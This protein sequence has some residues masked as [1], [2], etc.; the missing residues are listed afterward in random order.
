MS[1]TTVRGSVK[2]LLPT[3]GTLLIANRG[4]VILENKFYTPKF[5]VLQGVSSALGHP[6]IDQLT[7]LDPRAS[8]CDR[9]RALTDGPERLEAQ[10]EGELTDRAQHQ[11]RR[12]PTSG[13]QGQGC[14]REAVSS[15][16]DRWKRVERL[17]SGARGVKSTTTGIS[18]S[19]AV[20]PPDTGHARAP[21]VWGRRVGQDW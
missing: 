12:R 8:T 19:A 2:P 18:S 10:G 3:H 21:G 16:L 9:K 14:P 6:I 17:G 7:R 15:D 13:A 1:L 11:G 20:K 4:V 5:R